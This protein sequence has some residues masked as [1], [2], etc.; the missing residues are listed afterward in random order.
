M[1]L[2]FETETDDYSTMI[3]V[4]IE[5]YEQLLNIEAMYDRA[6]DELTSDIRITSRTYM[7]KHEV[8][9]MLGAIREAKESKER[10][11]QYENDLE[12]SVHF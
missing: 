6:I 5:R 2:H 10:E 1:V 8:L 12:K 7:F 3:P 4:P 9:M 11:K